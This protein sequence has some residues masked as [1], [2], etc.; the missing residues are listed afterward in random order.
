MDVRDPH[1][2]ADRFGL[3]AFLP[4]DSKSS[5]SSLVAQ[6]DAFVLVG[7]I[8]IWSFHVDR[9]ALASIK[10]NLSESGDWIRD[11]SPSSIVSLFHQSFLGNYHLIYQLNCGNLKFFLPIFFS[12]KR[13]V[14]INHNCLSSTVTIRLFELFRKCFAVQNYIQSMVT[15][16]ST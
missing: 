13:F 3:D 9:S 8:L 5:A 7:R 6:L 16:S 11:S 1:Q 12:A 4:L 14:D 10:R 15:Q 2:H